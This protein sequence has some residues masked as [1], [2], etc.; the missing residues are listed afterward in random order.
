MLHN[1]LVVVRL[2]LSAH[3]PEFDA[4]KG[5]G[6]RDKVGR[7]WWMPNEGRFH[8]FCGLTI[9]FLPQC[10]N[11][12]TLHQA[13]VNK[14]CSNTDKI[15]HV[16]PGGPHFILFSFV[17]FPWKP[18]FG[19]TNEGCW[20]IRQF[21]LLG[22]K[23]V[24]YLTN[25]TDS[26]VFWLQNDTILAFGIGALQRC[27]GSLLLL[28]VGEYSVSTVTNKKSAM[29]APYQQSGAHPCRQNACRE[30]PVRCLYI[31]RRPFLP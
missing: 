5:R 24:C 8:H 18:L 3:T 12:Q 6:N 22:V 1:T 7:L 4:P 26:C 10:C 27:C 21:Q 19:Q 29:S 16:S 23:I 2:C 14:M 11:T 17:L 9:S 13:E 31:Y 30:T 15:S 20:Q 28:L 25:L